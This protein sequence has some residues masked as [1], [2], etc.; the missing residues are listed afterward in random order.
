MAGKPFLPVLVINSWIYDTLPTN[1]LSGDGWI[2]L[3]GKLIVKSYFVK[4]S[5]PIPHDHV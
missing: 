1:V 2:I 4:I 3:R 5:A